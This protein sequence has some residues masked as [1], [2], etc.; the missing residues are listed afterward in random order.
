MT[1]SP[2]FRDEPWLTQ[3]LSLGESSILAS[4]Q[5]R[6]VAGINP[7]SMRKL[8]NYGLIYMVDVEGYFVDEL[9]TNRDLRSGDVVWIHPGVAHAY[10][11]K[12]GRVWTQIYLILEGAQWERWAAEGVLDP[13]RP[14]THAEPVEGWARRWHE[15]FPADAAPT[16]AAALRTFGAVSQLMLELLAAH[17]ESSRSDKDAWLLESQR[18]LGERRPAHDFSP[19]AVARSVGM[20]YENFRKKFAQ[21]MS[22][23]PGHYQK[24][25]RIEHACAAIYQGS[26]SFKALA[27]ELGFC[28]VFHFS[29]TFRQIV[30]Q[31]P[32][33][34]RAKARGL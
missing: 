32:S 1:S 17:D 6:N 9:G 11:P 25:R 2:I 4:G 12:Q 8:S 18:L 15:V 31:T 13:R 34:F 28:D 3:P 29:K 24:R 5:V 23:S 26:H 22:E 16:Y 33:E 30:G 21:K 10:G 27:D 19:Q 7:K 14:V 20:S